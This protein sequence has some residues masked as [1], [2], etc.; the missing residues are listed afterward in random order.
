VRQVSTQP[1]WQFLRPL[2][3]VFLAR[4]SLR[5]ICCEF[6]I[7]NGHLL[8]CPAGKPGVQGIL[9]PEF[10]FTNGTHI[11]K[12]HYIA[13]TPTEVSEKHFYYYHLKKVVVTGQTE[14]GTKRRYS[15]SRFA[16][17]QSLSKT[18]T[19]PFFFFFEKYD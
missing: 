15:G 4:L 19:F 13:I 3:Y 14:G 2:T 12:C 8:H 17:L 1:S 10:E 7:S 18:F 5:K 16:E 11:L 9:H 6:V